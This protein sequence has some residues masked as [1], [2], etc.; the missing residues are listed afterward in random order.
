MVV[1]VVCLKFLNKDHTGGGGGW[2]ALKNYLYHL[3][4][5]SMKEV[6]EGKERIHPMIE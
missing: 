3:E 4:N 2:F 1:V 6:I 5:K